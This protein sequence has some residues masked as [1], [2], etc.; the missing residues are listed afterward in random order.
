MPLLSNNPMKE[1]ALFQKLPVSINQLL[2]WVLVPQRMTA[3]GLISEHH[4]VDSIHQELTDVFSTL[5]IKWKWQSITL[6]NMQAIVEEI[7][8]SKSE[9][10]PV[11]LNYCYGDEDPN[12]PGT[13]VYELLEAAEIPS[14]GSDSACIDLCTSKLKMKHAFIEAGVPTSPYEVISDINYVP[15]VCDRLGAPLI[16]KPAMSLRSYGITLQSVVKSDEQVTAQVQR[17][18]QGQHGMQF[19]LGSIYV[20]QF[21][22]G[23][24]FT[25]FLIGSNQQPD[26]IKIYPPLERVFH[27][28]LPETERFLSF[29]RYWA[30]PDESFLQSSSEAFC[31]FQLAALDLH[32]KLCDVGKRA[33]CAVAGNGYGRVDIR[34]DK[35]SQQ[36]FV[37]EV[38][39]NCSISSH[40]I[41]E[42][43]FANR[44]ATTVGTILHLAGIPFTQLIIEIIEEALV[45]HSI[46]SQ[47]V[48]KSA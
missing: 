8:A 10:I 34:M 9:S 23:L 6:E 42:D 39:P 20:E 46:N 2:V 15:G 48:S 36:M 45:R 24:E 44:N 28:S 35:N 12:Y 41:G 11:V 22:N 37:L 27:S 43:S 40:P 26:K 32:D 4:N 31:R 38:N 21:I 5:G 13:R 30:E 3:Q 18:L 25:V 33:Y 14:T 19:P 17:L 29:E 1:T 7:T 47:L 16:V